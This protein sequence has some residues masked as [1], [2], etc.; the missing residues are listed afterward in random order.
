VDGDDFYID[1]LFFNF[2][3]SRFVGVELKIGRFEPEHAGQLAFYVSW[4]DAHLRDPDRHSP[5]SAS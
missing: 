1:L 5:P 2:V 3:Q 4:I